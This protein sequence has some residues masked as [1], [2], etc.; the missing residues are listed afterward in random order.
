MSSV[1]H[2]ILTIILPSGEKGFFMSM[3]FK[4]P[5]DKIIAAIRRRGGIATPTEIR[6]SIALFNQA[7]GVELL[8]KH[9]AELMSKGVI[10]VKTNE[11]GKDE[12]YC[13]VNGM[14]SPSSNSGKDN[15]KLTVTLEIALEGLIDAFNSF[16]NVDE[17][18][19]S[20]EGTPEVAADDDMNELL[21]SDLFDDEND[22]G[23]DDD[24]TDENDD[25]TP[26]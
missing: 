21:P 26:F 17:S 11:S 12:A 23:D 8:K 9:L 20:S 25:D 7:G 3:T 10:I 4:Y 18:T 1:G 14:D 16:L 22:E 19:N 15:M 13:L 6:R 24:E 2:E 5:F